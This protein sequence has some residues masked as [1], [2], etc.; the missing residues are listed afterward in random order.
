MNNRELK[1]FGLGMIFG[2]ILVPILV[3]LGTV[4]AEY[5]LTLSVM[6][7]GLFVVAIVYTVLS[8]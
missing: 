8:K 3:G 6:I 4:T 5:S 7:M 1:I 2:M